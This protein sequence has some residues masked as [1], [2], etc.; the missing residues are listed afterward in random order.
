MLQSKRQPDKPVAT[1]NSFCSI[2]TLN[3]VY[4]EFGIDPAHLYLAYFS[5]I[6]AWYIPSLED[7][8]ETKNILQTLTI[9]SNYKHTAH[10]NSIPIL[11]DHIRLHFPSAYT[12]I[13]PWKA[14]VTYQILC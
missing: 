11:F 8:L 1:T 6:P 12:A 7:R 5:N 13:R 9:L 10:Q 14:V 2:R 4:T 3:G